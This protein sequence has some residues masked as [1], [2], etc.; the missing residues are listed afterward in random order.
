MR[1]GPNSEYEVSLSTGGNVLAALRGPLYDKYRA[2]DILID[3]AGNWHIDGMP[4]DQY[5]IAHRFDVIFNALHGSYGEDGKVQQILEA[6]G[7]KFTGSDSLASAVGMNKGLSKNVFKN[8]GLKTPVGREIPSIE[9]RRAEA[10]ADELFRTFPMPAV[11]KPMSAGSSVGVSIVKTKTEL[12]PAL[13]EAAKHGDSVLIE[14][15]IPGIEATVAVI[16]GFRGQELYVLPVIE[17][18]PKTKFFDYQAK[19]AGQSDEIVPATFSAKVKEELAELAQK[20]HRALGLRHYS[21]SDF[22]ISPRRGIYI[23]ESNSLPGLTEQSLVPKAL[24]SVG[25][26]TESLVDH[27]IALAIAAH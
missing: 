7:I 27:L 9:A 17:I 20:A 18:R 2:Y 14:E 12:V 10:I 23:L 25:S 21:R 16:E 13:R 1:G 22:I 15:Y 26:D 24:R 3:K 5:D 4:A 6:H 19:Y 11:V 8:N